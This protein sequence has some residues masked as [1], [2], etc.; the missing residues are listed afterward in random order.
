MLSV[1][2]AAPP[3]TFNRTSME[4]KLISSSSRI[5]LGIPS[6]NRTSMELKLS[7]SRLWGLRLFPFNRTS[8]ELK[9]DHQAYDPEGSLLL[10][11][12]VWN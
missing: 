3:Q 9:P 12:P 6:F 5:T 10:I 2:P 4:L 8:M 11:E 1:A 7:F